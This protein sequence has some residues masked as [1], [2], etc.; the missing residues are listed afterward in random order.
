MALTIAHRRPMRRAGPALLLAVTAFGLA[1]I[2]FGLSTYFP[3]SLLM[4]AILGAVDNVSVVVRQSLVQMRT[5]DALRGRV[6]AVNSL[7]IGA[8]N[9][10]GAFES[11]LVAAWF[12]AVVSVVAGGVG[13]IVVVAAVASAWPEI[14]RLGPLVPEPAP[15]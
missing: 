7:F 4:L 15:D 1:T 6:S 10:L 13:T 14:R 11:G 12:G 3:L 5:P 8:S 9:E 2:G